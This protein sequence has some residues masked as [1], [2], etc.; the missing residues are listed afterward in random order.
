MQPTICLLLVTLMLAAT[1]TADPTPY[2][3][4]YKATYNGVPIGATGIR[5][6]E[7]N[8]QGHYVLSS[9]AKSFIATIEETTTFDWS[10]DQAIRPLEYQYHRRG[11]GKNESDVLK[12]HRDDMRVER[13][14]EKDAWERDYPAGIQDKLSYQQE[15]RHELTA[16]AEAGEDWPEMTYHVAEDDG[17]I[18]EYT[19]RVID[20]ETVEVP[21]G[22]FDTVKAERVRDHDRRTTYFWLAPAHEFLLV[23]LEHTEDDGGGFK[24]LLKDA[25]LAGEPVVGSEEQE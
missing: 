17:R 14:A 18:R 4:V 25:Q 9:I 13:V 16:A 20:R 11:L 6:L 7:Q 3:A 5:E 19:F 22:E 10:P 15:M 1:A 21:A 2:R 12:F 8:E 24:L 23:R